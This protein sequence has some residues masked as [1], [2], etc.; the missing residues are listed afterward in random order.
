Y[1]D[2]SG[3]VISVFITSTL[4]TP[5]LAAHLRQATFV[6]GYAPRQKIDWDNYGVEQMEEVRYLL[7]YYDPLITPVLYGEAPEDWQ[8]WF[9]APIL[10]WCFM[11]ANAQ[12]EQWH[13]MIGGARPAGQIPAAPKLMLTEE[14]MTS[15]A[16]DPM[17]YRILNALEQDVQTRFTHH[18]RG[19]RTARVKD[20]LNMAYKQGFSAHAHLLDFVRLGH[21]Y[22]LNSII[23]HPSW[24]TVKQQVLS[25]KASLFDLYQHGNLK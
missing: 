2:V 16:K 23:R 25:G 22:D 19:V 1:G 7:R 15:L 13:Q 6:Y 17:P 12:Q 9:F 5:E 14:L 21:Q 18:C 24:V 11:H 20:M 10:S 3:D 8:F 4:S